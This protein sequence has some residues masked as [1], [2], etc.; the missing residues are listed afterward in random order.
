MNYWHGLGL[1]MLCMGLG[2]GA[3]YMERSSQSDAEYTA[4]VTAYARRSD[5]PAQPE[6]QRSSPQPIWRDAV[7]SP[8]R[9]VPIKFPSSFSPR[10]AKPGAAPVI[11]KEAPRI[12]PG[13]LKELLSKPEHFIV[14]RTWLGKPDGFQRFAADPARVRG[15]VNNPF[16]RAVLGQPRV[17]RALMGNQRLRAAF[18]NSPAMNDPKVLDALA[19]SPLMKELSKTKGVAAVMA[20]PEEVGKLF[21]APEMVSWLMRNPSGADVLGGLTGA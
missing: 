3:G 13:D 17:V 16:V 10:E 19:R 8:V 12:K 1:L 4:S 2:L 11:P 15:Y 7:I 9:A 20:N 14:S 21:G 6:P 5:A 18:L